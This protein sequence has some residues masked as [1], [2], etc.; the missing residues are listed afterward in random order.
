MTSS[1]RAARHLRRPVLQRPAMRITGGNDG[2][3]R[4]HR[5]NGHRRDEADA[6]EETATDD[7]GASHMTQSSPV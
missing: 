7:G 2:A 5:A 4:T 1:E 6:E 3:G